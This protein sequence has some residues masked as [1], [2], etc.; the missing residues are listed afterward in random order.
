MNKY[1]INERKKTDIGTGVHMSKYSN[2]N[3]PASQGNTAFYFNYY[4]TIYVSLNPP[5]PRLSSKP[6]PA[7]TTE[8]WPDVIF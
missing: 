4:T 6:D 2:H 5:T 8:P 1:T 3:S 7:T